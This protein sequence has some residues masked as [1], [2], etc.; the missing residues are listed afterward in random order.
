MKKFIKHVVLSFLVITTLLSSVV[1]YNIAFADSTVREQIYTENDLGLKNNY[2]ESDIIKILK[3]YDSKS[4]YASYFFLEDIF[5]GRGYKLHVIG[6]WDDYY[7]EQYKPRVLANDILRYFRSIFCL[8]QGVEFGYTN[9]SADVDGAD[10]PGT[11]TI[12]VD[13]VATPIAAVNVLP[14]GHQWVFTT[15]ANSGEDMKNITTHQGSYSRTNLFCYAAAYSKKS[16]NY[17]GTWQ[18][19]TYG[20]LGKYGYERG[21]KAM[22]CLTG[23]LNGTTRNSIT[24]TNICPPR[25]FYYNANFRT[26]K[27]D[28]SHD[29]TNDTIYN[30]GTGKT[31]LYLAAKAVDEY[32]SKFSGGKILVTNNTI[33]ITDSSTDKKASLVGDK[34]KIGPLK[35]NNYPY[36]Y[37]DYVKGYSGGGSDGLIGGISGAKIKLDTGKIIDL[38][39][40]DFQESGGTKRFPFPNSNFNIY[41]DKDKC[42]GAKYI[43]QVIFTY[44]YT[45]TY[46]AG[47]LAEFAYRNKS[48]GM[49]YEQPMLIVKQARVSVKSKDITI[50]LNWELDS[51]VNISTNK[52][53]SSVKHIGNDENRNIT[54]R[55]SLSTENKTANPVYVEYGDQVTYNI[56]IINDDVV[57][58]KKEGKTI[59]TEE[60]TVNLTDSLP[61]KIDKNNVYV[62]GKKVTVE[63]SGKINISTKLNANAEKT[64]VKVSVIVED[65]TKESI[66]TNSVVIPEDGVKDKSG[67]DITN[68]S[69]QTTSSD[70]YKINDY[71]MT[72]KKYVSGYDHKIMDLNNADGFT[73][74]TESVTDRYKMSEADKENKPF[75]AEQGETV[76]YTIRLNNNSTETPNASVPSGTK[77]A[78]SVRAPEVVDILESGLELQKV[79]AYIYG[80][81][82]KPKG[83][84]IEV[85]ATP[86]GDNKYKFIINK[87]DNSTIIGPGEYIAYQVE[88]KVTKSNMYLYSLVNVSEMQ[89]LKN[90]NHTDSKNRFVDNNASETER[91]SSDYIKLKDLIISGKVWLDLDKDGYIGK[92]GSGNLNATIDYNTSTTNIKNTNDD[93][94]YAMKNIIVNLYRSG[95]DEPIRTAKTDENGIFTFAKNEDGS[96]R[97]GTYSY[98]GAVTES[99]QRVPKAT[100]KD[101]NLNYQ[102]IGSDYIN[103]FITYEYDG[104]IYKST[105]NYSYKNNLKTDGSF[106]EG[107]KYLIDSNAAESPFVR[108]NFDS[109]YEIIG[110]NKAYSG[111]ETETLDYVKSGHGSYLKA[112][113]NT[114]PDL[115]EQYEARKITSRSFIKLPEA[116]TDFLWLYKTVNNENP[117]T[118]YLK[119]INLGLEARTNVNLGVTQDVYKLTNY[120]DGE[121]MTYDY[122]Q[123]ENVRNNPM[124]AGLDLAK[125]TSLTD[126]N[127][128]EYMT[129]YINN[130]S[131]LKPYEFKY[132]LAD[133]NYKYD[134]YKAEEVKNYK[135]EASELNTE[136]EFRIKVKNN[137][138][139]KDEVYINDD[140]NIAYRDIKVYTGVDEVIEYFD[141]GFMPIFKGDEVDEFAIKT[142]D[143]N[144]Y[145]IE[146][147]IKVSDIKIYPPNS[148]TPIDVTMTKA[149]LEDP[150]YSSLKSLDGYH[151]ICIK[152]KQDGKKI[153]LAEGESFDIIIKFTV[154]KNADKKNIRN[155]NK[156]LRTAIAEIGAYSTYYDAGGTKIAGLTDRNSNPGNFGETYTI[157]GT[158]VKFDAAKNNNANDPYLAMYEDDTFKA[159]IKLRIPDDPE[160]PDTPDDPENPKEHERIIKGQVWDD[161]RSEE[162]NSSTVVDDSIEQY[163]VQYIG[164]GRNGEVISS[165]S[166]KDEAKKNEDL[167]NKE[168][169]DF[170]VE[171]VKVELVEIVKIPDGTNEKIYE[172]NVKINSGD[173]SV[174]STRTNSDGK[175]TLKGYIPAEYI[176]RFSYGDEYGDGHKN[177]EIFNGQAYK[178]T[179]YQNY[180]G[181]KDK[182]GNPIEI[183]GLDGVAIAHV[184]YADNITNSDDR[185]AILEAEGLSD[186]KDDEI[187]RLETIGYSEK[188]NNEKTHILRGKTSTDPAT[189]VEKTNMNSETV[190]F[191]VRTEK[192]KSGVEELTYEATD[193]KFKAKERHPINNI[194]FGLQYRPEQQ[195]ALDKYVKD[196]KLITSAAQGSN[197]EPLIDAKFKEYYGIIAETDLSSGVTEFAKKGDDIVKLPKAWKDNETGTKFEIETASTTDIENYVEKTYGTSV[198]SSIEALK[199]NNQYPIVIAGTELDLENSIGLSNLQYLPNE[200]DMH[201]EDSIQGFIYLNVDDDILQGSTVEIQYLF[202]GH[203]ISEIDRINENLSLLRLSGNDAA[204]GSLTSG[205]ESAYSGALTALSKLEN[206]YY[207]HEIVD[208]KTVRKYRKKDFTMGKDKDSDYYGS[209]LGSTYYIGKTKYESSDNEDVVAEL[210]LNK[211]LDYVDNN[212]VFNTEANKNTDGFWSTIRSREL[213]LSGHIEK[214]N[215]KTV[216][217][218][219]EIVDE[220][221]TDLTRGILLDSDGVAYD[222]DKRSNLAVLQDFITKDYE[223]KEEQEKIANYNIT[224]FLSPRASLALDSFGTVNIVLT[225]V[226]AA[227]EDTKEMNYENVGEIIELNSETGRITNF[228]TTLGNALIAGF[229]EYE[230]GISGPPPEQRKES[231]TASVEKITLTPPTGL[232]KLSPIYKIAKN[233]FTYVIIPVLIIGAMVFGTFGGIKLYRKRKIK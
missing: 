50:D 45:E 148:N 112:V 78:T 110:N 119:Y 30:D 151:A 206:E 90:I 213:A 33:T 124:I 100:G 195:V 37:S 25:L 48:G 117:K 35:I 77:K 144:G 163:G 31:T 62:D 57:K 79:E 141:N 46:G 49:S 16:P 121:K 223:T 44:Q 192:E 39:S 71:N 193:G 10:Y 220:V 169:N 21:Q 224:R 23:N 199:K 162:V 54:G 104:L 231:D 187:R 131:A 207:E 146:E 203:N 63:D 134:N 145:L 164:D 176:V 38:D 180:D 178:S 179:T 188:L 18:N 85:T 149:E 109:K 15:L 190:S 29:D 174:I 69:T 6:D 111:G 61:D 102:K 210:K 84:A 126:Y 125:E 221:P 212:L 127:F 147:K 73:K 114:D 52:Y 40:T 205:E 88:V 139:E 142:K 93:S 154:G 226:I 196:V 75:P 43:K 70:S 51:S 160:D 153:I 42:N 55:D 228:S 209:Y 170:S 189:Q 5:N 3:K 135:G 106:K 167:G 91:R 150:S 26:N 171:D 66:G 132:Y 225:K 87:N 217:D 64:T 233:V 95:E 96:W 108:E 219:G 74:E 59:S 101:D 13:G 28:Y 58:A 92:N 32:E 113:S 8:K 230:P 65:S 137:P 41:V 128:A 56:D 82:D 97:S 186:A 198:K 208:G 2:T 4:G 130:D 60:L 80:K 94:E 184:D 133:Y 1:F 183:K 68:D 118:D 177:M 165:N 12:N 103:Y 76:T 107:N 200:E 89:T 227:E 9:Y 129:G 14:S 158:E 216:N 166:A 140:G 120:I 201:D 173:N 229:S 175:Y 181:A 17:L 143:D 155:I 83:G 81:D 72:L 122:N 7:E 191:I 24:G 218:S 115:K 197:P 202:A 172:E 47:W 222:T 161:A 53:I 214:G 11:Y 185:L 34:Y 215:F 159:G 136:I 36:A 105:T 86:D 156:G 168:K 194:D 116:E 232:Y 138:N 157:D 99:E 20:V 182:S 211:I 98:N 204:A 19:S 27:L 152:P 22:W 123:N 67:N